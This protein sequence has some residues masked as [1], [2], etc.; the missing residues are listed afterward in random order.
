MSLSE[1]Y[2]Y[3]EELA[4]LGDGAKGHDEGQLDISQLWR[5]GLE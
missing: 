4:A 2:K 1:Q 3:V 5:C